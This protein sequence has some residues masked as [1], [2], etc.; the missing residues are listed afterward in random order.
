MAKHSISTSPDT[1]DSDLPEMQILLD[2]QHHGSLGNRTDW[3]IRRGTWTS[4][5]SAGVEVIELHN[6]ELSLCVLPTRGVGVWKA[7]LGEIPVGWNS[8]VSRPVHPH[9]VNLHSRNGL[10]WLDGFNE[11]ICRC[12]LANNGPPGQDDGNPSPIES[13]LT[14]HGR[15]A[16]LAAR[17]VEVFLD[18]ELNAIGL[19]GVVEES[20]LFGPRLELRTTITTRIGEPGFHIRDE[21]I[22]RGSGPTELQLLYH[23][24]VGEPF[25]GEGS[26]LEMPHRQVCPRDSRAAEGIATYP[27]CEG[28]TAGY[29]EQVYFYEPLPDQQG[30]S[31]AMLRNQAGDRGFS[32]AWNPSQLPSFSFWKCTQDLPAGYVAGLEPGTN[33]PNFK[34]AERQRGRVVRL[35][36]GATFLSELQIGIHPDRKSVQAM[37]QRIREIQGASEP[38]VHA[39]PVEPFCPVG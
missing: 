17:D 31:V 4:G 22:N 15:I 39:M 12:G 16:N 8:P 29:A 32:V 28:P 6:G 13:S 25:L 19:T 24:N 1:P 37:S 30:Q 33:Y 20:T 35:D 18:E 9:S 10:G 2:G 23:C 21:V 26:A 7:R 5:A 3:H 38:E 11:L 14:L 34:S 36:E 27:D